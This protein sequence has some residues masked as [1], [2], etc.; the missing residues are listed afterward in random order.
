MLTPQPN[1]TAEFSRQEELGRKDGK[2]REAVNK[3]PYSSNTRDSFDAAES[4]S[5][6][7][8][9]TE[10]ITCEMRIGD[11]QVRNLTRLETDTSQE[12]LSTP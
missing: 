1:L 2:F 10:T 3:K 11:E 6:G 12:G 4:A 9:S 8:G 5:T 7:S